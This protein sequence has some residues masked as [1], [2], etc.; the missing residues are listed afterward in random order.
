MTSGAVK[1]CSTASALAISKVWQF[2]DSKRPFTEYCGK[3]NSNLKRS[4]F[5]SHAQLSTNDISRS[6]FSEDAVFQIGGMFDALGSSLGKFNSLM[7]KSPS[8]YVPHRY[9][10]QT[11]MTT[12]YS[13]NLE[14]GFESTSKDLQPFEIC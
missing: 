4:Y 10:Y 12:S 5:S 8:D 9:A 7:T 2:E 3:L 1:T 11:K 13:G 14:T 6:A